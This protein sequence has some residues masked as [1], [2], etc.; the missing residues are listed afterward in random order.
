[1]GVYIALKKFDNRL[2]NVLYKDVQR[3]SK[4]YQQFLQ[5]LES[6]QQTLTTCSIL[7]KVTVGFLNV[8]MFYKVVIFLD[9]HAQNWVT[10]YKLLSNFWTGFVFSLYT[11]LYK[12]IS[13][14]YITLYTLLYKQLRHTVQKHCT[15]IFEKMEKILMKS[16]NH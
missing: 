3:D 7:L 14:L 10:L 15:I 16:F 8:A 13:T 12:T 9:N 4:Y 6:P 1:M 2:Y 11:L 5:S